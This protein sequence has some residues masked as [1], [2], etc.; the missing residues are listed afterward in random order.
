MLPWNYSNTM[1]SRSVGRYTNL[2]M[3]TYMSFHMDDVSPNGR[4]DKNRSDVTLL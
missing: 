4:D 1:P 2:L 3:S